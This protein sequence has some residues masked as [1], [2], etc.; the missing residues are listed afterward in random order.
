MIF[1]DLVNEE[2]Q[3]WKWPE[4]D[5]IPLKL[6]PFTARKRILSE[7]KQGMLPNKEEMETILI[8]LHQQI[9]TENGYSQLHGWTKCSVPSILLTELPSKQG[10]C[11]VSVFILQLIMVSSKQ[12]K[13]YLFISNS[14]DKSAIGKV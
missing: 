10:S 7:E 1:C 12:N 8:R 6:Q 4:S 9:S 14:Y 13:V 2:C 3:C 11:F 5:A